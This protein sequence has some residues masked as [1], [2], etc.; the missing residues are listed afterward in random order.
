[1]NVAL[2]I[3]AFSATNRVQTKLGKWKKLSS[4]VSSVSILGRCVATG[5][6]CIGVS[7]WL[8]SYYCFSNDYGLGTVNEIAVKEGQRLVNEHVFALKSSV[9][10]F[11][12]ST[13][14]CIGLFSKLKIQKLDIPDVDFKMMGDILPEKLVI[15]G[16]ILASLMAVPTSLICVDW[17]KDCYA[18]YKGRSV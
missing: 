12:I 17:V 8:C 2:G 7:S 14:Y 6:V 9:L 5:F 11:S 18:L 1:M 16:S 3:G 15:S 10:L 4:M 13:Y